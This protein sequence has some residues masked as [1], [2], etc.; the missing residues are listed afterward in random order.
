MAELYSEG[1]KPTDEVAEEI[2]KRLEA[3]GNYIPS[4]DR[5]R[6]EYAYVLLKEYRKYIKDHSDSGR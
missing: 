1:R 6:R 5:A 3:K 2:I 4:S